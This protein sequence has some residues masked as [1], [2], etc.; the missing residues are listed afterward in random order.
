MLAG[1][2]PLCL[3][4]ISPTRGEIGGFGAPFILQRWRLAKAGVTSDLPPVG[5]MAGRPGGAR[6]IA[7]FDGASHC[8]LQSPSGSFGS[9]TFSVFTLCLMRRK[10][11]STF[12]PRASATVVAI[13]S[14]M[15]KS[16]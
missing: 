16:A 10:F 2:R 4:D 15:A 3:P 7:K 1:Q 14:R 5:E 11:S 8:N 6:R 13:M 9:S 12:G